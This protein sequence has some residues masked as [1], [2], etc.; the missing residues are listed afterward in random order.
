MGMGQAHTAVI[1]ST[2]IQPSQSRGPSCASMY[3]TSCMLSLVHVCGRQHPLTQLYLQITADNHG[4]ELMFSV[5]I[6]CN[7]WADKAS[8]NIN[9]TKL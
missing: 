2:N 8:Y 3:T 5:E 1:R 7:A 9:E 4:S 6:C